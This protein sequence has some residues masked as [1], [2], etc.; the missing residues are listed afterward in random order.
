MIHLTKELGIIC[1][2]FSFKELHFLILVDRTLII[3]LQGI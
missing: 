3:F 1:G 2:K